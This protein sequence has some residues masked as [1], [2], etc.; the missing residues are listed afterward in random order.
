MS[1]TDAVL[2]D[3]DGHRTLYVGPDLCEDLPPV[4]LEGLARRRLVAVG[5]GCPCGARMQVPNRAARRAAARSG[6]PVLEVSV[7]HEPDCPAVCTEL[8]TGR[9]TA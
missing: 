7:E 8:L 9:W 3:R 5:Q 6:R 1:R 2:V 4:V